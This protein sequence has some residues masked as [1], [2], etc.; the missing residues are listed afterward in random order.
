MKKLWFLVVGLMLSLSGGCAQSPD[1]S[2]AALAALRARIALEEE[3]SGVLPL[4]AA[5]NALQANAGLAGTQEVV[6]LGRVGGVKNPC[7]AAKAVFVMT[8][9]AAD[10][11]A[12]AHD[13]GC[14]CHFCEKAQA[15][16]PKLAIVELVDEH[17]R[18]YPV[19]VQQ[20]ADVAPDQ[21][22]VVR[23]RAKLDA[24]GNLSVA[25]SGI[26]VRR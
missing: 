4:L 7:D 14:D 9:P 22:V 25:A 18:A 20:L 12:G 23:G 2:E 26:Y 10:F 21:M 17:G 16:M 3:P 15:A 24:L 6:V 5:V 11:D 19:S 8:D 13:A 1:L